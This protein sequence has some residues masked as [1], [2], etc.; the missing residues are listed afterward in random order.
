MGSEN[1]APGGAPGG[2]IYQKKR[3]PGQALGEGDV[4]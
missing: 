4:P 1:G 2:V 3:G